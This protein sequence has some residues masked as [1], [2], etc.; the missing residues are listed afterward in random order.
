[1]GM[2]D[3]HVAGLGAVRLHPGGQLP[4]F[5]LGDEAVDQERT[6]VIGEEGRGGRRPGRLADSRLEARHCARDRLGIHDEDVEAEAHRFM[7]VGEA[8]A[9]YPQA[10]C[11]AG[12]RAGPDCRKSSAITRRPEELA[13]RRSDLPGV[14]FQREVA[15]VDEPDA[16]LG[17]GAEVLLEGRVRRHVA[18][19]VEEPVELDLVGAWPGQVVVVEAIAVRTEP[20]WLMIAGTR[21]GCVAPIDGYFGLGHPALPFTCRGPGWC[22]AARS[23]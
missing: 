14:G 10:D 16:G 13:D 7:V 9:R 2:G 15:G 17:N 1:V 12:W 11:T 22:S 20:L 18:R 6:V 3:V 8:A 19:V 4:C 23:R 5:A 21:S